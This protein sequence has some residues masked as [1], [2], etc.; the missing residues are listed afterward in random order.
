VVQTNED[1]LTTKVASTGNWDAYREAQ[2]GVLALQAG[3]QRLTAHSE[4]KI[5]GAL[6]DLKSIRLV[7]QK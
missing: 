5:K 1:R 4:G 2:V 6:I 7:P 3:R